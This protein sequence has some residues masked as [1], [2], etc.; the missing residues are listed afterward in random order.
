MKSHINLKENSSIS[1]LCFL[2]HGLGASG[3]DLRPLGERWQRKLPHTLFLSPNGPEHYAPMGGEGFRW[4]DLYAPPQEALNAMENAADHLYK[5]IKETQDQLQI[6]NNRVILMG[7]SQGAAMALHL[8]PRY[9]YPV[10][11]YSGG[12]FF[13]DVKAV[14]KAVPVLLVH[15]DQDEVLPLT[16][17]IRASN[18]LK[19]KGLC[20]QEKVIPGLGHWIDEQ[21]LEWGAEFLSRVLFEN[22]V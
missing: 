5:Q 15:G 19:G 9:G 22:V 7:F 16:Y 14:Y 13:E 20:P 8:G 12:I 1:S 4:F 11:A 21:G 3:E 17:M 18:Y 10:M 6:D 2:L